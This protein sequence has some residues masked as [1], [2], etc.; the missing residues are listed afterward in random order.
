LAGSEN[1]NFFLRFCL[2]ELLPV[3]VLITDISLQNLTNNPQ[4]KHNN[5]AFFLTNHG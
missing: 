3:N 4:H 2:R 5:F 1:P